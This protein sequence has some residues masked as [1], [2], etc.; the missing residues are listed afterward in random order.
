MGVLCI[1]PSAVH[2]ARMCADVQSVACR[3]TA[4]KGKKKNW[5]ARKVTFHGE[6]VLAGL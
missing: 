2:A 4:V 6:H 5:S 1:S 3:Y